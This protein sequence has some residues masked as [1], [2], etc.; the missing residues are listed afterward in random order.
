[1]GIVLGTHHALDAD[2]GMVVNTI[3]TN[4]LIKLIHQKKLERKHFIIFDS[5][6]SMCTNATP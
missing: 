6:S 4:M 2:D 1:M 3:S 5:P